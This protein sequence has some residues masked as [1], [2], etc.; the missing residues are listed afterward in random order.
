MCRRFINSYPMEQ[1]RKNN[2]NTV[3]RQFLTI[4]AVILLFLSSCPIKTGIRSL[5]GLP[6]KVEQTT[7][8]KGSFIGTGY[9]NCS[10]SILTDAMVQKAGIQDNDLLP[11]AILT[12][13]VLFFCLRA[14]IKEEF[15]LPYWRIKSVTSLPFFL[16]H[17]KLII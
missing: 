6:Q 2:I 12:V 13:L 7:N 4:G 17:R 10:S 11:S 14:R 16:R 5:M 15:V 3:V 9:Q 1:K 8:S